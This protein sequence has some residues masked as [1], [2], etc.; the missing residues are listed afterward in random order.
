MPG[1]PPAGETVQRAS[2]PRRLAEC[3]AFVGIWMAIGE[4][5]HA[6]LNA[7][8]LIGVPLTAA[9]QLGLRRRRIPELWVRGAPAIS[10][11]TLFRL[12]AVALAVYPAYALLDVLA[13]PPAGQAALALYLG[14]A[15]L[16]GAA[17]AYAYTHFELK[18][19]H[20]L[21]FSLGTAGVIGALP[22]VV[23]WDFDTIRF[24]VISKPDADVGFGT[25]SFL[26]YLPSMYLIE[27]VSFRAALG[28]H[29]CHPDEGHVI[30]TA[31]FL[32]TLWGVWH[33]PILG[34]SSIGE[35]IAFHAVVGTFLSIAWHNSGN[36]GVT[37]TTHAAYDAVRTAL[38]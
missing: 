13:H 18:T 21:V 19:W 23:D 5:T 3:A 26:L 28:S 11:R 1:V 7:Y 10:R 12:L 25:L 38:L 31:I 16:G 27:E 30:P 14:C 24:A 17:G 29:A 37:A 8:L 9:F 4:L 6:G 32:A 15:V 34:W 22:A 36:L 2:R 33:A 20:W 35:L